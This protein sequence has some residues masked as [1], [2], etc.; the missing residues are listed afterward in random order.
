MNLLRGN[1]ERAVEKGWATRY[2]R[3]RDLPA[4]L[5][6]EA[7]HDVLTRWG[8]RAFEE[9]VLSLVLDESEDTPDAS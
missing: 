5:L 2:G 1:G 8:D 6:H 3:V 4:S 9:P 7:L